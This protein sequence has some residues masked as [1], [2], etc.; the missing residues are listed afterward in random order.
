[1]LMA[2]F[3]NNPLIKSSLTRERERE[4]EKELGSRSNC[5]VAAAIAIFKCCQ[6]N[7]ITE[8]INTVEEFN[9]SNHYCCCPFTFK[10]TN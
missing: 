7:I 3:E 10:M 4:K 8:K 6:N 2:A 9:N 1:M 5:T